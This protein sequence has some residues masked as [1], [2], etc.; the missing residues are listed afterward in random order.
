[1]DELRDASDIRREN[2]MTRIARK[3]T[4]FDAFLSL[5]LPSKWMGCANTTKLFL[6]W[7]VERRW[8]SFTQRPCL[9]G[10]KFVRIF[11]AHSPMTTRDNNIVGGI[12]INLVKILCELIE[13]RRKRNWIRNFSLSLTRD[14][15]EFFSMLKS[16]QKPQNR[17]T[18]ELESSH[19]ISNAKWNSLEKNIEIALWCWYSV[20]IALCWFMLILYVSTSE[21]SKGCDWCE[22]S[23]KVG[24]EQHSNARR[25]NTKIRDKHK[26]W[27][28]TQFS[29]RY[30]CYRASADCWNHHK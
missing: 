14:D 1:M 12:S 18:S 8:G 25:K 30:D 27:Q 6:S 19:K 15:S 24:G 23:Q 2:W 17:I 7:E 20:I 28:V 13:G 11:H 21:S 9:F 29:P 16:S 3:S 4:R 5:S 10:E 22:V 26:Y